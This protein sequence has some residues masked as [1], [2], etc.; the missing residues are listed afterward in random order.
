LDPLVEVRVL[1]PEL[2]NLT[3]GARSYATPCALSLFVNTANLPGDHFEQKNPSL[4]YKPGLSFY[5]AV[6]SKG[7]GG[8]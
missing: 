7:G 5:R 2:R 3:K 8:K 6:E 4:E 1:A